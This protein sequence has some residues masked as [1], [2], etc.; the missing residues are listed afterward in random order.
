MWQCSCRMQMPDISLHVRCATISLQL[1]SRVWWKS[2]CCLYCWGLL[3]LHKPC[4]DL[5]F[6]LSP[7]TDTLLLIP[8]LHFLLSL[9]QLFLPCLSSPPS[10]LSCFSSFSPVSLLSS[11]F[12]AIS[13]SSLAVSMYLLV[14]YI[15]T[16]SASI[17]VWVEGMAW[18]SLPILMNIHVQSLVLNTYYRQNK[19]NNWTKRKIN[20]VSTAKWADV[21][22]DVL[23]ACWQKETLMSIRPLCR[24]SEPWC[25]PYWHIKEIFFSAK[26]PRDGLPED[27]RQ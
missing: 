11:A 26:Q 23:A 7:F 3:S 10:T 15:G 16:V 12:I 13:F 2:M 22:Q 4:P 24:S 1:N 8:Y 25:A 21:C 5:Q 19:E 14:V 6:S 27:K 9:P 20:R 18:I 17:C